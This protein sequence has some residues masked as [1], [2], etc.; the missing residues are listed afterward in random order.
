[1]VKDRAIDVIVVGAGIGGIAA[2][3]SLRSRG[4]E[5]LV[6]EAGSG[7]GG[8]WFWN[9]Y[10]GARCDIDS[11]QYSFGFS[12]QVA[13]NWTWSEKFAPQD[14]I[15]RYVEYVAEHEN[16]RPHI[17][18]NTRIDAALY[19]EAAGRWRL[20]TDSGEILS[21][22]FCVMATGTLS[23]TNKP[24]FPGVDEFA[25]DIHHT[26]LW[27]HDGVDMRGKRVGVIGTG[28]SGVQLIPVAAA[29]AQHVTVFQRTAPYVVPARNRP[30]SE[31]EIAHTRANYPQLREAWRNAPN[32]IGMNFGDKS[33]MEVDEATRRAV[34]EAA[35][36]AGGGDF[37]ACFIDLTR[38]MES[39]A[40]VMAYFRWKI[41]QIVK[42]P[43]TVEALTPPF[44]WGSRRLCIGTDYYETYNRP[45]VTLVDLRKTPIEGFTAN[46]I[47]VGGTEYPLDILAL[48]T[49]FDAVTGTLLRMDIRGRGGRT[50]RDVWRE[51]PRTYLGMTVAGFP[52]LFMVS[53]PQSPGTLV[54]MAAGSEMHAEWIAECVA[55]A[56]RN[57]VAVIEASEPAQLDCLERTNALA[58]KSMMSKGGG[59]WTG[60]NIPGKPHGYLGYIDWPGYQARCR[61]VADHAYEGFAVEQEARSVSK[62]E[63]AG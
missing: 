19:D 12:P 44:L 20:R 39:N 23:T 26:G 53:G 46:G 52:N 58:A 56:D 22:R 24:D 45:N 32:A 63:A 9:R 4:L 62:L 36:E 30:L 21:A 1:M 57:G 40:E 7:L 61:E 54:N 48:A 28:S 50:L 6:V 42:D 13:Q 11:L 25:G 37:G 41:A 14:E 51:G 59:W 27:P 35:W 16:M 55:W 47:V 5:V 8:T 3:H 29:E 33:A 17:R 34:F 2:L 10:P 18:F 60:D 31:A 38:N 43:A 49:G 15:R